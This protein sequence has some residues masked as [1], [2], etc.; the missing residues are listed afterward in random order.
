MHEKQLVWP[1]PTQHLRKKRG[2]RAIKV[3][4]KRRSSKKR[5]GAS[6]KKK[7]PP[8]DFCNSSST[9]ADGKERGLPF[10]LFW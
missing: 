1:A 10:L 5:E 4:T 7:H 9:W 3:S 6:N 8:M 2:K